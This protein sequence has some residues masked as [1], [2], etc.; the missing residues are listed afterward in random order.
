MDSVFEKPRWEKH[1]VYKL[2]SRPILKRYI[3]FSLGSFLDLGAWLAPY[4]TTLVKE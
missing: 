2:P 1:V 3:L 4:A